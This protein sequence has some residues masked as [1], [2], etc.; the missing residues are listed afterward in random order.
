MLSFVIPALEAVVAYCSGH[1]DVITKLEA[2][3][4][5]L[6]HGRPASATQDAEIAFAAGYAAAKTSAVV[7]VQARVAAAASAAGAA[8]AAQTA[9]DRGGKAY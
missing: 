2:D 7:T 9:A 6:F 5:A 8:L 1:P 4:V 3:I